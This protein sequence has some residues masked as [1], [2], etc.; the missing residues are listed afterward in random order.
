MTLT[1]FIVLIV[2]I[3]VLLFVVLNAAALNIWMMRRVL[4]RMQTRIGPNRV[5]PFGLLQPIADAV[6]LL[7]KEDIIPSGVDRTLFMVAP[8]LL[9]VPAFIAFA[10][11]PFSG[12]W[13]LLGRKIDPW[14]A[15][16]NIGVLF[17]LAMTS[18]AVY[19]VVMGGWASNNKYAMMGS[20][21]SS[22]QMVSYEVVMGL[23]LVGVLLY[24]G[25]LSLVDIVNGQ[26]KNG[27]N[28]VALP[29]P[30]ILGFL[31]F[32]TAALAETNRAPFD[33]PEA[34][35]E[36]VAGYHVEYS[37]VRFFMFFLAELTSML[38]AACLVT[39][40]FFGGW[41]GPVLPP[42]VWFFIKVYF[43]IFVFFWVQATLPRLRYDELM[44]FCWKILLPLS[45]ANLFV[46]ALFKVLWS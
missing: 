23:S 41:S 9:A 38:L 32:F 45:L 21:R 4:G 28:I 39:V 20:L 6:K 37:G 26:I 16:L 1:C 5:G 15:N 19:G 44:H 22:A 24:S 29:F 3:A 2:K 35:S 12:E 27:W 17:I 18:L 36:L 14:V 13:R 30:Q 25:S 46:T 31:L 34:E 40:L 7:T 11:I 43:F 42:V 33:L 10:V 8:A